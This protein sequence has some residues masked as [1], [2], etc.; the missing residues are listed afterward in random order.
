MTLSFAPKHS[1]DRTLEYIYIYL[2][3]FPKPLS[4]FKQENFVFY[5]VSNSAISLY[6]SST[7][8]TYP[9][10]SASLP[11]SKS[12][13]FKI[14][15]MLLLFVPQELWDLQ[16]RMFGYVTRRFPRIFG[17]VLQAIIYSIPVPLHRGGSSGWNLLLTL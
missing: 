16:L 10:L 5:S 11:S 2:P 12:L 6:A 17:Y 9:K 1:S 3:V 14:P 13:R 7:E 4:G 15:A 8:L